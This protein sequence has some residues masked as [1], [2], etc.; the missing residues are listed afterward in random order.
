MGAAMNAAGPPVLAA[1]I[2]AGL[3]AEPGYRDAILGDLEEEFAERCKR[4]GVADARRWYWSQTLLAIVPLARSRPWSFAEGM[5]LLA[6]VT[7][8]Y[9]LVLKA[10]R[11]ESIAALRFT[12][13]SASVAVRF[14]L[15]SCI[16]FAGLI[17]GRVIV[18]VL[19]REPVMGAL[20]LVSI[21]LG[22]GAYHVGTGNEAEAIFR[23]AKVVTL[24]CTMGIGSLLTLSRH[25]RDS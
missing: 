24:M 3:V 18:R 11:V 2:V 21:T 15:L 5:R 6:T 22:V 8:T 25:S 19:P 4:V 17:A 1:R 9:L 13:V 7:V 20:L 23:G 16:A 12:P 10:I 14:V